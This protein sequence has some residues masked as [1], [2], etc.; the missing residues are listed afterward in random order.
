MKITRA[1]RR[2]SPSSEIQGEARPG[3]EK[4]LASA[5]KKAHIS[6]KIET[7]NSQLT[8]GHVDKL[9]RMLRQQQA[10]K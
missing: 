3:A 6:S 7:D 5:M 9:T 1:T 8:K 4:R 2:L 10:S